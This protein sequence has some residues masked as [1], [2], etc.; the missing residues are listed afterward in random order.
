[1][2]LIKLFRRVVIYIE[3][4]WLG[5][6]SYEESNGCYVVWEIKVNINLVVVVTIGVLEIV[7]WERLLFLSLELEFGD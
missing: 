3:W 7:S 1:M 4:A 5:I 2:G 6:E